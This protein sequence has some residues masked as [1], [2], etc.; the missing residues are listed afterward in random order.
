[1]HPGHGKG[2][3]RHIRLCRPRQLAMMEHSTTCDNAI[4]SEDQ[5]SLY[6]FE[7]HQ[8]HHRGGNRNQP[9]RNNTK[10]TANDKQVMEASQLS[11][12]PE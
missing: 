11:V 2:T 1:M 5:Y 6:K 12:L 7:I 8:I 9:Q 10:R 4:N 3:T